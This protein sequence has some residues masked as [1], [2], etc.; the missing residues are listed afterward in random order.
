VNIALRAD[1]GQWQFTSAKIL[2]STKHAWS[3][4]GVA[5]SQKWLLYHLPKGYS[6][7]TG[8]RRQRQNESNRTLRISPRRWRRARRAYIDI[9]RALNSNIQ[10]SLSLA[11]HFLF[12]TSS[13]FKLN[14]VSHAFLPFFSRCTTPEY[15]FLFFAF[16]YLHRNLT[17]KIYCLYQKIFKSVCFTTNKV[18]I[19]THRSNAVF[20]NKAFKTVTRFDLLWFGLEFVSTYCGTFAFPF[21]HIPNTTRLHRTRYIAAYPYLQPERDYIYL[22]ICE[23]VSSALTQYCV[24]R[25]HSI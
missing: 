23:W 10:L 19:W 2:L 15:F 4:E 21:F 17:P 12:E 14:P 5:W 8:V 6:G 24:H 25:T 13:C 7:V 16:N 9:T 1:S 3:K 11:Q 18:G 20:G 22:D